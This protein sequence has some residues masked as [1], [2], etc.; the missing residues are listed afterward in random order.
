MLMTAADARKMF[1]EIARRDGEESY[2]VVFFAEVDEKMS[3]AADQL[4]GGEGNVVENALA[5]YLDICREN[6]P[7]KDDDD[8]DDEGE[9]CDA[10]D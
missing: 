2:V 5:V 4:D 3:T 1:D 7:T 10:D 6:I 8:C 9:D